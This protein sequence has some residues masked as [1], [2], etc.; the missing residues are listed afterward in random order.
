MHELI[1]ALFVKYIVF[2]YK[3]IR[4]NLELFGVMNKF[5]RILNITLCILLLAAIFINHQKNFVNSTYQ[6]PNETVKNEL[7]SLI[8]DVN[9]KNST[10]LSFRSNCEIQFNISPI[11]LD[12]TIQYKKN[13]NFKMITESAFGKESEIGS[14]DIMFWFWS[15]R[16]EPRALYYAYNTDLELTRLKA[17]FNPVFVRQTLG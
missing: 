8:I 6:S 3:Y 13:N 11:K 12:G 15:K 2:L 9:N 16:M 1:N 10:I 4:L 7:E 17:P 5:I 14:N